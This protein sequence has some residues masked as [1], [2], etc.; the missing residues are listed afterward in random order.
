MFWAF[1]SY[2]QTNQTITNIDQSIQ[3]IKNELHSYKKVEK[4]NTNEGSR[5]VFF[6]DGEIRL[7]TVKSI[8]LNSEK[9]VEWYYL[10]GQIVYSET[11]WFDSKTKNNSYNEKCYFNNGHLIAWLN[12][13]KEFVDNSSDEF[14]KMDE[15]LS[16]YCS[17][18]KHEALK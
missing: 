9:N 5:F 1:L 10:N 6:K 18:I 8:E 12:P 16:I 15:D 14:K 7:I 17:K 4:I 13:Q 11:N 3:N 2:S